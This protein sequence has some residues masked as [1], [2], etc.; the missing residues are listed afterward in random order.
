M[1]PYAR[2]RAS[3]CVH[4]Y[5]CVCVRVRARV[6]VTYRK[7]DQSMARNDVQA[8]NHRFYFRRRDDR[9]NTHT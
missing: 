6:N 7:K 1:N 4:V 8:K 2:V 3:V 9:C 5:I